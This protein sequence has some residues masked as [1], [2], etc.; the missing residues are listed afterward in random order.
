MLKQSPFCWGLRLLSNQVTFNDSQNAEYLS[1]F[2]I[3][4]VTTLGTQAIG[5]AC[6]LV[7]N[8]FIL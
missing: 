4:P 7:F 8:H 3:S 5:K 6:G 2:F 1:D